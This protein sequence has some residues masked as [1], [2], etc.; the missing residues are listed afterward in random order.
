MYSEKE[1]FEQRGMQPGG[2][3]ARFRTGRRQS[4]PSRA[5]L[6][7]T[8]RGDEHQH[9]RR[10][11][12]ARA[13]AQERRA[14]ARLPPGPERLLRPRDSP[15]ALKQEDVPQVLPASAR[16]RARARAAAPRRRAPDPRAKRLLCARIAL[17][18][19]ARAW[20][21]ALPPPSRR[22]PWPTTEGLSGWAAVARAP[23]PPPPSL[24][25]SLPLTLLYSPSHAA[26]HPTPTASPRSPPA[27]PPTLLLPLR[28]WG[29]WGRGG[30]ERTSTSDAP[31]LSPLRAASSSAAAGTRPPRSPACTSRSC[32]SA[33]HRRS[34]T[35][36]GRGGGGG[37]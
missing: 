7:A 9:R 33:S 28:R 36:A 16:A 1:F 19:G 4:R 2:V 32:V 26:T 8:A 37:V 5:R 14:A 6:K 12:G 24:L 3:Q 22:A 18:A 11:G 21:R 29:G 23:P 34:E 31:S 27:P 20:A 30:G 15:G 10:R 25:F 13:R 17:S 35:C